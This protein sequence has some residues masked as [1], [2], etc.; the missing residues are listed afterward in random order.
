MCIR[1]RLCDL[2]HNN[3][4]K[5]KCE[6]QRQFYRLPELKKVEEVDDSLARRSDL[7]ALGCVLLD[8]TSKIPWNKLVDHA[9][10]KRRLRATTAT[11]KLNRDLLITSTT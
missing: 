4:H 2:G 5:C 11:A 9:L 10:S 6:L 3:A 7:F 1:D 8:A